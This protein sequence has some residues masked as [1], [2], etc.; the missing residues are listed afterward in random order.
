LPLSDIA[1]SIL[2]L[3]DHV[4]LNLIFRELLRFKLVLGFPPIP[5]TVRVEVTPVLRMMTDSNYRVFKIFLGLVLSLYEV[6]WQCFE[7]FLE[8][9]ICLIHVLDEGEHALSGLVVGPHLKCLLQLCLF[10]LYLF[11]L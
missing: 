7:H 3:S 10:L 4:L 5:D 6:L 2:P 11:T 8:L 1:A 9:L